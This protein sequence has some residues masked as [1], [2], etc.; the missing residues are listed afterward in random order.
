MTRRFPIPGLLEFHTDGRAIAL[1]ATATNPART[2]REFGS[3]VAACAAAPIAATPTQ[4]MGARSWTGHRMKLVMLSPGPPHRWH[5]DPAP[6][7]P[8]DHR[9]DRRLR[10]VELEGEVT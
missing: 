7:R 4:A 3:F 10:E 8:E 5:V 1:G 2:Q 9:P 6:L